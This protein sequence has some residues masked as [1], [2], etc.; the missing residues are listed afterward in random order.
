MEE[1]LKV[2]KNN[3][4]D[5][6]HYFWKDN[7]KMHDEFYVSTLSALNFLLCTIYVYIYTVV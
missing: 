2:G 4:D 5:G 1:I 6:S 3:E 7:E